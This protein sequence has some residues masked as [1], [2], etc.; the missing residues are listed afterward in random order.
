MLKLNKVNKEDI[1][2]KWSERYGDDSD[3]VGEQYWNAKKGLATLYN[4]NCIEKEQYEYT[5]KVLN[6][7]YGYFINNIWRDNIEE[8]RE[9]NMQQRKAVYINSMED[10][11]I[12]AELF[13]EFGHN[14]NFEE[15]NEEVSWS[16]PLIDV[17]T[18][19]VVM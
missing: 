17:R 4:S 1:I 2:K 6:E 14:P 19:K 15:Y 16:N 3:K 13:E 11:D 8:Y 9:L 5:I 7:S 12:R 18:L 10:R